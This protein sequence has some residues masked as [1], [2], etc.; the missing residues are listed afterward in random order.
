[1]LN[2]LCPRQFPR[3]VALPVLGQVAD[4]YDTWLCQQEYGRRARPA[5]ARALAESMVIF[6]DAGID[7]GRASGRPISTHA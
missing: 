4:D 6:G 1:M 7:S 3:L 2:Q 5:H